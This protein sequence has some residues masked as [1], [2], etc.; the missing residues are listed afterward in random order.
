VADVRAAAAL[1]GLRPLVIAATDTPDAG[2]ADHMLLDARTAGAYGGTGET[3]DWEA[4]AADPGLPRAG[5]VLAGGLRPANV[6]AAIHALRPLAV[7][8][9]SGVEAA[10]G[11][12]DHAALRDFFSAVVH[13]DREA[14]AAAAADALRPTAES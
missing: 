7:D 9:S 8:V 10:P 11:R 6:A 1:L 5:L 14:E 2:L 13:A 3:L 4:L 12:K